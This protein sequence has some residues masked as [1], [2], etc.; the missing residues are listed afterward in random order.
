MGNLMGFFFFFIIQRY[1]VLFGNKCFV[2]FLVRF[3]MQSSG[4]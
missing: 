3:W 2:L 1:L 4:I